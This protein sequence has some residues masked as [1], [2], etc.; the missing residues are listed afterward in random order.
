MIVGVWGCVFLGDC[1]VEEMQ[2][3]TIWRTNQLRW[4]VVMSRRFRSVAVPRMR[5]G[6]VVW[7]GL[8][9]LWRKLE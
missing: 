1:A 5:I 6:D 9:L 4:R 7:S 3:L 2:V 8:M